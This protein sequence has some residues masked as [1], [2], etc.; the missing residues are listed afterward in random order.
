VNNQKI[1]HARN[2]TPIRWKFSAFRNTSAP[3]RTIAERSTASLG[4]VQQVLT[5]LEASGFV[6]RAEARIVN[7]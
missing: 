2:P 3:Y 4:T 6:Y 5:G 1:E 7:H